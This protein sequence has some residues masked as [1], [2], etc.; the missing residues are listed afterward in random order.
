MLRLVLL[1]AKGCI[2]NAN[3]NVLSMKNFSLFQFFAAFCVASPAFAY[4]PVEYESCI[5]NA[6]TAVYSKGLSSTLQD[7]QNYCD[8][9]LTKIV[10]E[11]KPITPS[12][13]R[14]NAIYIR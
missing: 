8:C 1:L 11:G 7:V 9:A 2:D 4:P 5:E 13:D 14:C 12:I 10:D 6:L 3:S